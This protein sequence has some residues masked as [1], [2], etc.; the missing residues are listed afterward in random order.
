MICSSAQDFL[1]LQPAENRGG[2]KAEAR[3]Q[4]CCM[5]ASLAIKPVFERFKTVVIT[6]GATLIRRS[7]LLTFGAANQGRCLLWT[8]SQRSSPSGR[9]CQSTSTMSCCSL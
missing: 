8:C 6:S 9:P 2:D 1:N 3:L 5:D 7:S 4:L